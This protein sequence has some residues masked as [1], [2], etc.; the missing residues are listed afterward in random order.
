MNCTVCNYRHEEKDLEQYTVPLEVDEQPTTQI[1]TVATCK[2]CKQHFGKP[3]KAISHTGRAMT[4]MF[5][6]PEVPVL[7]NGAR[8]KEAA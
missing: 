6:R 8:S 4:A 2:N 1:Y 3:L 7:L 5:E